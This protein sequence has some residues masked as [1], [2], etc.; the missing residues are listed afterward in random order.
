MLFSGSGFTLGF[1]GT[2]VSF[3]NP[4]Q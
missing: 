1:M 4:K 3:R 2:G